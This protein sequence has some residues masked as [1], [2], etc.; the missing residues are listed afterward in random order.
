MKRLRP[1]FLLLLVLAITVTSGAIAGVL[2]N[3]WGEPADLAL[4]GRRIDQIPK[5][6]G[7]WELDFAGPLEDD[8]VEV[9]QCVGHT[10]RRYRN[11]RTGESVGLFVI[12]GPPGPTS[13]HTPEICY[14]S[15]D[16]QM[17]EK[18][19][20]FTVSDVQSGDEAFWSM[21]FRSNSLD[22][23]ALHVAYA[24]NSGQGWQA[25]TQPRFTFGGAPLLYKLQLSASAINKPGA[26]PLNSCEA[27]LQQFL[28]QL[29]RAL[30]SP[31]Q[32]P[33]A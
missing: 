18:P 6:F 16:Y 19:T 25:P 4:A 21:R 29:D 24:W 2:G 20:R 8:V 7:D 32:D 12:V 28:P 26:E 15:Q 23:H 1:Y 11:R 22:G 30:F 3:R 31:A 14:S 5:S 9:L 17:V 33:G 10:H 27:F 13:V